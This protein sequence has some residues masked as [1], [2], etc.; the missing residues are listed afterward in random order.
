MTHGQPELV[1]IARPA[2]PG[3]GPAS[4]VAKITLG[5]DTIVTNVEIEK[6]EGQIDNKALKDSISQWVFMPS[7]HE[8][9]NGPNTTVEAGVTFTKSGNVLIQYPYPTPQ[10]NNR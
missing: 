5:S 8:R 4:V 2:H 7:N 6:S 10:P 1:G 3:K 9:D